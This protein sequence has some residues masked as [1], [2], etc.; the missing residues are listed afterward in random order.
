MWGLDIVA[1]VQEPGRLVKCLRETL[2][3]ELP[4]HTR[5]LARPGKTN[6]T[7]VGAGPGLHIDV[8]PMAVNQGW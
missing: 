7:F 3:Q 4:G 6:V 2:N 8:W 1:R 5:S